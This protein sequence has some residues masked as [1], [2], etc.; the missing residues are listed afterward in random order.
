M[1]TCRQWG[2]LV[3]DGFYLCGIC[4]GFIKTYLLFSQDPCLSIYHRLK[5]NSTGLKQTVGQGEDLQEA[6]G[7]QHHHGWPCGC[8]QIPRIANQQQL[9]GWGFLHNV[10]LWCCPDPMSQDRPLSMTSG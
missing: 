3:D 4:R 10:E 8:A 9:P 7:G 2:F 1:R 6:L 5:E